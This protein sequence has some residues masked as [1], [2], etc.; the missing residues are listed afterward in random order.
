M[1]ELGAILQDI[2]ETIQ[3]DGWSPNGWNLTPPYC[4]R[5]AAT[6]AIWTTYPV[7]EARQQT[8][9]KLLNL[10]AETIHDKPRL[11]LITYWEQDE[12]RTQADIERVLIETIETLE[13]AA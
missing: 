1:N 3:Q 9:K 4:L 7:G 11:G 13:V 8:Y 5:A 10:L 2:L 12:N 6:Q